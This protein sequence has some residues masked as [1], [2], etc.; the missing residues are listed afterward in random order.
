M[1]LDLGSSSSYRSP[2]LLD[3]D[4]EYRWRLENDQD[5]VFGTE[6]IKKISTEIGNDSKIDET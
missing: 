3:V 2:E 4:D 6:V 5:P 1:T